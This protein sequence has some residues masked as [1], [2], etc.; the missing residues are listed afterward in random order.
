MSCERAIESGE[1]LQKNLES[2]LKDLQEFTYNVS[3]QQRNDILDN[4]GGDPSDEIRKYASVVAA[5]VKALKCY[6]ISIT[7][8]EN[9]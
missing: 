3:I 6:K 5:L 9:L 7:S 8:F 4:L 2:V 1:A